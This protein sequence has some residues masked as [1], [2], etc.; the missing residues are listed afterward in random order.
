MFWSRKKA[1][2]VEKFG[3]RAVIYLLSTQFGPPILALRGLD[4]E[5]GGLK[6]TSSDSHGFVGVPIGKSVRGLVTDVEYASS[7]REKA[8]QRHS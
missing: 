4:L 8:R 2:V 6:V 5:D 1:P 7:C 3:S